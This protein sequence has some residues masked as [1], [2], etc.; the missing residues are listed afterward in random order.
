MGFGAWDLWKFGE[1]RGTPNKIMLRDL[2]GCQP[3]LRMIWSGV[4][5]VFGTAVAV[6]QGLRLGLDRVESAV[7]VL[8]C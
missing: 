8:G 7:G 4:P 2:V 5:I 6:R 1:I 3:S